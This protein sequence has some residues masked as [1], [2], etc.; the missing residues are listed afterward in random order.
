MASGQGRGDLSGGQARGRVG[1]RADK[2]DP[3]EL[4]TPS[5]GFAVISNVRNFSRGTLL[6]GNGELH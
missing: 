4:Y 2:R 1:R 6:G 3:E 5:G